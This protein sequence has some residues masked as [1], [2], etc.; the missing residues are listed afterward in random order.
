M[1]NTVFTTEDIGRIVAQN[2]KQ[3]G[4]TQPQ[5]AA[6]SGVGVRFIVDL[7]KGKATIQTAKMLR[8]LHTLGIHLITDIG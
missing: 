2:R 5:L 6:I 8:V 3:Q 7:E 1:K 4:L